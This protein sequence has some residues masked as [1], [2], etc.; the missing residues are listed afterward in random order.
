MDIEMGDRVYFTNGIFKVRDIPILYFPVGYLP[1]DQ[2]RKS[3]LLTP[4]WG[5]SSTEGVT[6]NNAYFWAINGHSDATFGLDYTEQRGFRPSIEYR[7]TPNSHTVGHFNASFIDDKITGSTF[8][9]VDATHEQT[10]PDDF[11]FKGKL[12]LESEEFN[13]NFN[14]S[15]SARARR[16]SDS[17]ATVTKSWRYSDPVS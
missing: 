3:G 10:L 9:K 11:E 14:D 5:N 12:D 16:N 7:Y 1:I 6:F 4:S 2:E 13:R 8:W 17:H 15:T